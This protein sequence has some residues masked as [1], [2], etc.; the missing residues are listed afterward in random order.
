VTTRSCDREVSERNTLVPKDTF[1]NLP[2]DKRALICDVAIDEFAEYPFDQASIN[3]V[4]ANSGIAKGSFYQYFED[5]KDLFL[6]I[7]GQIAEEKINY[8][9]PTL[10]NPDEHDIFTLVRELFV[11][12]IQF[13]N[14]HPRYE[15]IG[16]KL[17]ANKDASIYKELKTEHL[18]SSYAIFE[19]IVNKAIAGGEVREDI[20]AEMITYL[21]TSMSLLI[22]E[23]SSE[24]HPQ[25]IYESMIDTVNTFMDILKNGIGAKG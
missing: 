22:V 12:G 3:R 13:A 1:L 17:L 14:E 10:R 24:F 20:S 19:K 4:V 6:Y 23:Y 15:A 9:S 25:A 5:K 21:V 2:E 7:I 8:I 11:S 18:P 16:N